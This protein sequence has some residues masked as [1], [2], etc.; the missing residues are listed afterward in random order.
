MLDALARNMQRTRGAAYVA[1][2]AE[3]PRTRLVDLAQSGSAKAMLPK[4]HSARPEIVFLNTAGGLTGGDRLDYALDLGPGA[5]ASATTQ[6]A[7]RAYRAADGTARM[8]VTLRVGAGANLHWLPQETI[9]F[10]RSALE[11]FTRIELEGDAT[12]LALEILVLG[13]TAM[14]ETLQHVHLR[15][16]RRISRDGRPLVIEPL[17]LSETTLRHQ[18]ASVLAGSR[19]LATMVLVHPQAEVHLAR[20]RAACEGAG[21]AVAASAWDGRLILRA[22]ARDAFSLRRTLLRAMTSLTGGPA[23]RVWQI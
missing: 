6:T 19:A 2:Q 15:D 1:L 3:G 4:V 10:E 23:P 11:R 8:N 20:T 12:C 21:I 7:E 9:L 17:E 22:M 5:M 13:R 18:G 16:E 14:G